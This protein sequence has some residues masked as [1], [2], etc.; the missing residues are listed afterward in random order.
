[1]DRFVIN[2]G[3]PLRGVIKTDGSKNAALPI[4]AA[5][6]LVDKGE[7]II[8]NVPPLRDIFTF[9]KV[10]EFIGVKVNYDKYAKVMIINA[11][12]INRN[13]APYE[14][15]RQMRASF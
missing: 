5:A 12:D 6:L 15:M 3:K 11:E 14:L 8:K 13:T 1:M 9:I 2:G 10:L 4:M 7:T